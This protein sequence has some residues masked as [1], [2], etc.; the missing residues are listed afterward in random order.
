MSETGVSKTPS[1]ATL[2]ALAPPAGSRSQVDQAVEAA[3][4]I[5]LVGVLLRNF[6]I[7]HGVCIR[8]LQR[9]A[10]IFGRNSPQSRGELFHLR[11][12]AT[13]DRRGGGAHAA[14][15]TVTGAKR[16]AA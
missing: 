9:K 16:A 13:A 2:D 1:T 11:L 10:R 8:G 12:Q 7:N 4:R 15:R 6:S 3:I 5:G 14:G